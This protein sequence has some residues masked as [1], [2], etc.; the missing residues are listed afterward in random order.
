M[1]H[2]LPIPPHFG[3]A[4]QADSSCIFHTQGAKLQ[5]A[6]VLQM[7][8][9]LHSI[10]SILALG[11]NIIYVVPPT[12]NASVV[13]AATAPTIGR[14]PIVNTVAKMVVAA[15]PNTAVYPPLTRPHLVALY[16]CCFISASPKSCI[17][18]SS[19]A[20]SLGVL[21]LVSFNKGFSHFFS[22]DSATSVQ[23]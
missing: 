22:K 5:Q 4:H 23:S 17:K 21:P 13:A 18:L 12:A 15:I 1:S 19:V 9:S 6:Q 16:S 8:V 2:I 11:F 7:Y 14:N 20:N 10:L 3:N